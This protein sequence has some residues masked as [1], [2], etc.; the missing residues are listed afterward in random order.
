MLRAHSYC[1]LVRRC[2]SLV[3]LNLVALCVGWMEGGSQTCIECETQSVAWVRVIGLAVALIV[4]CL[5]L[6]AA[7]HLYR[8]VAARGVKR[9]AG[10]L[11]WVK[12]TFVAG[13]A[14]PLSIYGKIVVSHYQV[15][16]LRTHQ[17]ILYWA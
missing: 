16:D 13:G 1:K 9:E 8:V 4:A 6:L 11:R 15:S 5:V 10:E 12:P 14:T 2:T 3:G 17:S 7:V